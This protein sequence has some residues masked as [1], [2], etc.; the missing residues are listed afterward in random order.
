MNNSQKRMLELLRDL[1]EN[2]GVVGVKA[3]FE[4]EATRTNELITLSQIVA[5]ADSDIFL[6]IG[7]CEAVSDIDDSKIFAT[8]GIIAPMI[9]TPFALQKFE[10][11]AKKVYG[12]NEEGTKFLINIETKTGYEN[13][14]AILNA[15]DGMIDGVV[16]GRVDLSASY[17]LDRSK[18]EN[19]DIFNVCKDILTKVKK[20]GLLAGMGGAISADTIPNLKKMEGVIVRVETRKIIFD[21]TEGTDKMCAGLSKAIE[22]EYLYIYDLK[23]RYQAM[24]SENS[25]RIAMLEQRL[26]NIH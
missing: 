25:A 5:R 14:D 1:K 18:I 8:R 11:A 24:A 19:E 9:E 13:L 21:I 12:D 23:Q 26:K 16:I 10:G 4:A 6:K 22:F 3:E 2:H 7:G 20:R 15:N 17:G